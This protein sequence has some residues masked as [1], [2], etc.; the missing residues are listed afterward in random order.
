[1]NEQQIKKFYMAY[2]HESH[3]PDPV[4]TEAKEDRLEVHYLYLVDKGSIERIYSPKWAYI[5]YKS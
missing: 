2:V 5:V 4:E 3:Y 1:M